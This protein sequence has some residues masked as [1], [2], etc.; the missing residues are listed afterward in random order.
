MAN[1]LLSYVSTGQALQIS[2]RARRSWD[3]ALYGSKKERQGSVENHFLPARTASLGQCSEWGDW[4]GDEICE[5]RVFSECA[6]EQS[7]VG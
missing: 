4:V 6:A 7:V 1:W 2:H 3:R 5:G